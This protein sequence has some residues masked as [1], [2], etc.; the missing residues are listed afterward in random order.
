MSAD[1]LGV[2]RPDVDGLALILRARSNI[3]VL[4]VNAAA[5][6]TV[7]R[8]TDPCLLR[9]AEEATSEEKEAAVVILRARRTTALRSDRPAAEVSATKRRSRLI[10]DP[11]ASRLP[12]ATT[13]T[14]CL[15]LPLPSA[16]DETPS[17]AEEA[18]VRVLWLLG[19]TEF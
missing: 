6:A 11:V 19:R 9:E 4:E 14:S 5:E 10:R 3:G 2:V 16:E 12:D 7:W 18:V 13:V 17:E 8:L 15:R 1:A